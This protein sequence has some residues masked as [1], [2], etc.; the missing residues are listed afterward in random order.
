MTWKHFEVKP[1]AEQSIDPLLQ[2]TFEI[3]LNC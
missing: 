1:E 2:V 3:I